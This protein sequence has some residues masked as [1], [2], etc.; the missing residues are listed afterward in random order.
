MPWSTPRICLSFRVLHYRTRSINSRKLKNKILPPTSFRS[1]GT[2]NKTAEEIVKLR[3][4]DSK[5]LQLNK[6]PSSHNPWCLSA[7]IKT[8]FYQKP[9]RLRETT[10]FWALPLKLR[11]TERSSRTTLF[12]ITLKSKKLTFPLLLSHLGLERPFNSREIKSMSKNRR[13]NRKIKKRRKISRRRSL[14]FLNKLLSWIEKNPIR[15][16]L[17]ALQRSPLPL[18]SL[19]RNKNFSQCKVKKSK[20]NL[21]SKTTL[22]QMTK[23]GKVPKASWAAPNL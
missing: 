7:K 12:S 9:K 19:N 5:L 11:S 6:V 2:V 20:E 21:V 23:A 3:T 1:S 14:T 10:Q 13:V 4:A 22:L 16:S 17:W 18:E 15:I 8:I